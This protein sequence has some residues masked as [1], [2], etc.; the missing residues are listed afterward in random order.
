MEETIRRLA[1]RTLDAYVEAQS[2]GGANGM[3]CVL[4]Y[5][6]DSGWTAKCP[7]QILYS[8]GEYVWTDETIPQHA[9][10]WWMP[11]L[12]YQEQYYDEIETTEDGDYRLKD[13]GEILTRSQLVHWIHENW[14]DDPLY[15]DWYE[16]VKEAAERMEMNRQVLG[17]EAANAR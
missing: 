6:G 14:H 5:R 12:D 1:E 2:R 4:W 17:L 11:E 15:D 16:M 10:A 7:A 8:S 9:I 13:T 3:V